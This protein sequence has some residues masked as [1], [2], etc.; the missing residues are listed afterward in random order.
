VVGIVQA[1]WE[2]KVGIPEKSPFTCSFILRRNGQ[3]RGNR[4][5]HIGA[6]SAAPTTACCNF[7]RGFSRCFS[8]LDPASHPDEEKYRELTARRAQAADVSVEDVY[9]GEF[10]PAYGRPFESRFVPGSAR[11]AGAGA[12]G[13]YSIAKM[14][15]CRPNAS[16]DRHD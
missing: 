7:K 13:A 10:F 2:H 16:I 9:C 11:R 4:Y 14:R 1:P 8:F 5:L 12:P 3:S 6:V 15:R